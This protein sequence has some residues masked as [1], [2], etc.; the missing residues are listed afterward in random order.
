MW[1]N[2]HGTADLVTFTQEILNG[3]LR[4]LCSI[5]KRQQ[6]V[7]IVTEY[8]TKITGS[9]LAGNKTLDTEVVFPWKYLSNFW[10][11]LD[12]LLINCEIEL[13]LSW[14]KDC[15]IS[16]ISRTPE[17][18]ANPGGNPFTDRVSSPQNNWRNSSNKEC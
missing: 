6:Q 11:F 17:V 8:N 10:R 9:T 16:E 4:F 7:N 13:D 18:P 12:L 5:T 14:L 2:P 3:K 15:V 1:P